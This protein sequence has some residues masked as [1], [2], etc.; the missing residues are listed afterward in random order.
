MIVLDRIGSSLWETGEIE[1]I[2]FIKAGAGILSTPIE[3]LI[4][5]KK[6]HPEVFVESSLDAS[7]G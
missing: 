1:K 7:I 6:S 5:K 4:P 2:Q 3:E